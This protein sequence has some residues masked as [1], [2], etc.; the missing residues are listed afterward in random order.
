MNQSLAARV[1]PLHRHNPFKKNTTKRKIRR[2]KKYF[3][4]EEF[5]CLQAILVHRLNIARLVVIV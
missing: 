4:E 5:C 1:K 2:L 3:A